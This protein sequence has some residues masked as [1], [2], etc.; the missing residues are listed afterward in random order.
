MSLFSFLHSLILS[1]ALSQSYTPALSLILSPP[2]SF[3]F[4][5]CLLLSL[6]SPPLPMKILRWLFTPIFSPLSAT[7][8]ISLKDRDDL[9]AAGYYRTLYHI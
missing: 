5:P 1:L 9:S 8:V 4:S 3:S 2:L 6:S 7:L